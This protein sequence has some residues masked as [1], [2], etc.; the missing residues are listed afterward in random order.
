MQST[1]ILDCYFI[2]W[3]EYKI[4]RMSTLQWKENVF[5]TLGYL[6]IQF[7]ER[8]PLATFFPNIG[9]EVASSDAFSRKCLH[10]AFLLTIIQSRSAITNLVSSLKK[11][12]F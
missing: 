8:K 4:N 2:G 6:Q 3:M 7:H 5:A 9:R 1:Q 11:K 12:M 10:F